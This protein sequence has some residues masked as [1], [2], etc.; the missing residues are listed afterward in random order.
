MMLK[1]KLKGQNV[2]YTPEVVE[3]IAVK[4]YDPANGA[5]P[6][7]RAIDTYLINPLINA[8]GAR[9]VDRGRKILCDMANG[10]MVFRNED[11][12]R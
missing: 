4:G 5:R 12:L 3:Y 8:M 6:I 2:A 1:S 9:T 7:D 10:E 11:Q